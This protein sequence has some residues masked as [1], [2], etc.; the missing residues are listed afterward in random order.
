MHK[1][2]NAFFMAFAHVCNNGI[3]INLNGSNNARLSAQSMGATNG[4]F[5]VNCKL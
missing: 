3:G 2:W 5:F 4:I 1:N